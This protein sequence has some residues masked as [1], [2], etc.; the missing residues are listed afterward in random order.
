MSVWDDGW[1][2]SVS[3]KYKTTKE[4]IS[5]VLSGFQRTKEQ[6]GYEIFKVKA[7][8]YLGLIETYE[9]AEKIARKEHVPVLIHVTDVTQPQGHSTSGSHERYKDEER[10]KF[11][12]EFCCLQK[13]KQWIL[14]NKIAPARN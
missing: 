11:E 2:I 14:E 5:E 12:E 8:D 9:K 4:S 13:T 7:W 6:P 1:G 10:L 3:K